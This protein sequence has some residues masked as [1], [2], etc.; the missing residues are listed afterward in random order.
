MMNSSVNRRDLLKWSS[1]L[2][3]VAAL[4]LSAQ[5]VSDSIKS[6]V[7]GHGVNSIPMN[8]ANLTPLLQPIAE[9]VTEYSRYLN[10]DVSFIN[11]R[12]LVVDKVDLAREKVAAM[13]G[14]DD[15]D[16][17]A[18]VRNTSEA[19]SVINNGLDLEVGDEVLLW[20]QNHSTNHRSWFY[21][22]QRHRFSIKEVLLPSE[23]KS[24][25]QIFDAFVAKLTP[26]TRVVTFTE[27][28]NISGLRLPAKELCAA[29]HAYN[30]DIFVHVDGAQSWGCVE[31]NLEQMGCD[32]FSSSAHKWFM[33]P[34]GTGILYVN[35]KWAS[36]IW[37][38]TLGYNFTME[39]PEE[40]LPEVARRF[41]CIGQRDVAP[42][43]AIGDCVDLF[44]QLG[45]SRAV[46]QRI[47]SLTQ[48]ALKALD[49]EA[50]KTATPRGS[51][52]GQS[53]GHGVV[54]ID[55]ESSLSVY[56]AF[57]ALHNEG[58]AGAFVTG[59]RVCCDPD[60]G[61]PSEDEPTYLRLSPH[62]YNSPA[63]IDRAIAIIKRIKASKFEIVKEVVRFL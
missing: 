41:E 5:A 6:D 42:Y 56:G 20:N 23:I 43:A 53:F 10:Q 62:V 18:F 29:I 57:L 25:Q 14:V 26:K 39:Y 34:R 13:L 24:K 48:Y 47:Q 22:Q 19:N 37:P 60:T 31:V 17:I 12:N 50:I 35:K 16:D 63:D 28:S 27:L 46:E 40:K 45:G 49:T 51:E 44:D 3:G 61:Q 8:A 58:I 32:S 2:G 54:V 9:K 7:F 4:P 1:V 15:P 30:P 36:R 59:A 21:R 55:L 52:D 11:R 38:N 33:G